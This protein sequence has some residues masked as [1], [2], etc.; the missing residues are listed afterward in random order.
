MSRIFTVT[1]LVLFIMSS[2]VCMVYSQ[3]QDDVEKEKEKYEQAKELKKAIKKGQTQADIVTL[4][5]EPE[6]E[7]ALGQ[8]E[9][10]YYHEGDVRIE[11]TNGLVSKWFLRFMPDKEVKQKDKKDKCDLCGK[12]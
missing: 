2:S 3:N 5:G 7:E 1:L 11:F 8:I 9:V 12:K 10:W 4:M 6:L